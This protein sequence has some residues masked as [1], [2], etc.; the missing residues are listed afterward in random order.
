M[1]NIS[2]RSLDKQQQ[3]QLF[4]QLSQLVH[5]TNK[6]ETRVFLEQL[7]TETEQIMFLKR[8]AVILLLSKNQSAYRIA[9][10]LK[11]SESTVNHIRLKYEFGD[12]DA[13]V[14]RS[15]KKEFDSKQFWNTMEVLL[16]GGMPPMGKKRWQSLR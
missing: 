10:T 8:L 9:K 12:Y 5:G 13:I 1:T 4:Y 14:K 6:N 16:R 15:K 11:M 2:K 3:E 7:F